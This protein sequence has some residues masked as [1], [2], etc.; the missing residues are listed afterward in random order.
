MAGEMT[1]NAPADGYTIWVGTQSMTE[2]NP[3]VFD[4]LRWKFDDF[5]AVIKGVIEAEQGA[6]DHY[7]K[8]IKATSEADP[9]PLPC[10]TT[11]AARTRGCRTSAASTSAG[12]IRKP[13]TL[14]C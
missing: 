10:A 14:T 11:A 4:S 12:S 6:I 13:R 5:A 7:M 3:S 2:I 8:L 1:A 9:A